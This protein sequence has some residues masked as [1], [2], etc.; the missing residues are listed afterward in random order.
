MKGRDYRALRRLSN[1]ADDTL[2]LPGETC[3]QVPESSLPGLLASKKIEPVT[4]GVPKTR[5]TPAPEPRMTLDRRRTE[6]P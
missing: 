3:E 4:S 1:A 6:R 5:A 2:A